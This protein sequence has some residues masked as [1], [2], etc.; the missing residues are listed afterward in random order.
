MAKRPG[1]TVKLS[2]SIDE[3]DFELLK[4]RAERG[5]GGNVSAAITEMIHLAREW[6]GRETLA[7]WLGAEHEE[8]SAETMDAIRAEWRG[9]RRTKRRTKAA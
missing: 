1:R 4:K 7:K 6:E 5:S 3:R 9:A 8:P 2:I